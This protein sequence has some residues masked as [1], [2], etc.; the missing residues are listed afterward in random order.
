MHIGTELFRNGSFVTKKV[1]Q[2][3]DQGMDQ[4]EVQRLY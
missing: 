2:G 4:E 3:E 1:G